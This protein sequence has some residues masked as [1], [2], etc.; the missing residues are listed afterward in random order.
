[1]ST[2]LTQEGRLTLSAQTVTL[3]CTGYAGAMVQVADTFTGSLNFYGTADGQNFVTLVGTPSGGGA[4][5]FSTTA[6][7]IWLFSVGGLLAVQV[8]ATALATGAA[9]VTL[10]ATEASG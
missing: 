2:A 5:V 9:R 8:K 6:P 3:A 4:A 10:R 7:G 1:M